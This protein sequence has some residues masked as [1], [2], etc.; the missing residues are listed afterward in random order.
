MTFAELTDRRAHARSAIQ[1]VAQANDL[2]TALTILSERWNTVARLGDSGII[3]KASTLADMAKSDP[4]H[5]FRQEV[6]VCAALAKAGAPVHVPFHESAVAEGGLAITLWNEIEGEMGECSEDELVRSLV[7]LH[8]LGGNLLHGQPWF[9][10]TL[11]CDD[12]H[13]F[14]RCISSTAFNGCNL[15]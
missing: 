3:A 10:P 11:V 12:H 4:L 6:E 5:W 15:I 13:T 9:A 8:R 7:S 1:R 2:P 14:R